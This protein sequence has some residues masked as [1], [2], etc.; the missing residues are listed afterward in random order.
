[1]SGGGNAKI[2]M[3]KHC[4]RLG[5]AQNMDQKVHKKVKTQHTKLNRQEKGGGL[6]GGEVTG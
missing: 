5:S 2:E 6:G 1:M 4:E 3:P